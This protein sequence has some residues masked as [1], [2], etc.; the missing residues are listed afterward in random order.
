MNELRFKKN[1]D[2]RFSSFIKFLES[3]KEFNYLNKEG[4]AK[5]ILNNLDRFMKDKL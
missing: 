5:E 2:N 1:K 3:K 4:V